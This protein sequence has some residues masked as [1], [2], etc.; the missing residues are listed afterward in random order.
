MS[1][2]RKVVVVLMA[3]KLR[4]ML[5]EFV[6]ENADTITDRLEMSPTEFG[7]YLLDLAPDAI[8][9]VKANLDKKG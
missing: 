5:E 2:D 1:T 9:L 6:N 3:K 4:E 8:N 7:V